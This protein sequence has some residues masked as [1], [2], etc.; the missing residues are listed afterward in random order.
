MAT[1]YDASSIQSIK[2]DRDRVRARPTLYV[3]DTYAAGAIHTVFEAVDN[4][5]DELA[6]KDPEGSHLTLIFDQ[7][8]KEVTVI[9]DGRGIPHEK[10]L[11]VCTVLNTSGKFNN[12][13]SSAYS[14]SG[15]LNG[16]GVKICVFLSKTCEITSMMKG[17]SLTYKFRDGILVDTIRSKTKEHGTIV[18]FTLDQKILDINAVKPEDLHDRLYEKSFLFPDITMTMIILNGGKETKT[19]TYTGNTIADIVRE[20]KPDTDLIHIQ[21]A[22]RVR[23]LKEIT[24]DNLTEDRVEVDLVMAYKEDALDAD[25]DKFIVSYANSIKTYDGGAHVEGFKAGVIKYIKEVVIPKASKRDKDLPITPTDIT[26]GLVGVVS[27]KLHRPEFSAQHKA[28]LN[29]QEVK[30]AVRDVVFDALCKEKPAV[31]NAIAE[32]IRRVTRGRMASKKTRKKDV[33][34]AFSKDRLDKYKEIVYNMQTDSPELILV[35]GDSA[36]NNAATARDPHNQAIYPVKKPK[37]IYD[38]TVEYINRV[39]TVF[40]DIMDICGLTVGKACDPSKSVMRYILMLT[41]GDVDG[42]NIAIS[43]VCLLGKHCRELIDAGMVGRILPPAYSYDDPKKPGKRKYA[44][45]KRELFETIMKRFVKEVTVSLN[46]K[47]LT[48]ADL[49]EFLNRNFTYDLR[50]EKLAKRCCCDPKVMEYIA[51][52]YHGSP[53]EQKKSYWVAA[54]KRYGE[55]RVMME[56][57]KVVLDGELH[58]KDYINL[59]MDDYFDRHINRFKSQQAQNSRID[60]Y[61]INGEKD[62]TLYDVM[63]TFRKYMPKDIVKFKGLGE[64]DPAELKELCMDRD[65]RTVIIFKFKNYEE[66]MAKI[67]II[68]S[69]KAEFAEARKH[70]LSNLVADDLD[71]DS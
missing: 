2:S 65:K 64:L 47:Q 11:D 19:Y 43:V 33:G 63:R 39:K 14:Q 28:R 32:F 71:L 49:M 31:T 55:I 4:S 68:M 52:K 61:T 40:N 58:G 16:I 17:K 56:N 48:K 15:G 25:A 36:S 50:L 41:D 1:K 6:I 24:D 9:D 35:E 70:I 44:H 51:W 12:T 22:K 3:P 21:D 69:T 37:N 54:M 57:G 5:I 27:V 13:D 7:K 59:A 30:F 38:N 18:R 29:N 45:S 42:D 60:G 10:L 20:W 8:T 67:D 46:G 34:N 23:I 26:S 66:D 62:Q 53:K